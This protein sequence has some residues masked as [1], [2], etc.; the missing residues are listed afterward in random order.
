M[1]S[2]HAHL[3]GAWH[4]GSLLVVLFIGAIVS[5]ASSAAQA[6]LS[7]KIAKENRD[8]QERMSNTAYQ[9]GM[10]D[11]KAAGLNPLLAYKQGGASTPPGAMASLPDLSAPVA[12][13]LAERRQNQELKNMKQEEH[14]T[15]AQKDVFHS[16]IDLNQQLQRESKAKATAALAQGAHSAANTKTILTELPKKETIRD[17]EQTPMGR[18]ALQLERLGQGISNALPSVGV[19]LGRISGAGGSNKVRAARRVL[20]NRR[21]NR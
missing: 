17:I 19:G 8:F 7:Y 20:R 10:A 5:A 11:M 3:F 9:R 1:R 13:A 4:G 18:R 15:E 16:Q 14:K 21:G 2:P 12:T 6:A